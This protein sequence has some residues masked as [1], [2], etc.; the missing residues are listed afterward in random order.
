[1]STSDPT[2]R[3]IVSTDQGEHFNLQWAM[4]NSRIC[5]QHAQAFKEAADL[6][7]ETSMLATRPNDLLLF[8]VLYLYRHCLE[9]ALKRLVLVGVRN[10]TFTLEEVNHK[11]KG[12][13][14]KHYLDGLWERVRPFLAETFPNTKGLNDADTVIAEFAELDNDGQSLRYDLDKELQRQPFQERLPNRISMGILRDRMNTVFEYLDSCHGGVVD[15]LS[16]LAA[17]QPNDDDGP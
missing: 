9:L 1:M 7:L 12:E 5:P 15:Y 10:G 4:M 2:D 14:G 16:E 17:A 13:L 8:P 6:I 3:A 11:K